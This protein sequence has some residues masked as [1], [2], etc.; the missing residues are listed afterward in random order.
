MAFLH[1]LH[2]AWIIQLYQFDRMLLFESG[3]WRIIESEM[4]VFP[5]TEAAKVYR[6]RVQQRRVPLAFIQ[7]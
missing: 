6:L 5:D 3:H 2:L 4:A 7:R 1:L